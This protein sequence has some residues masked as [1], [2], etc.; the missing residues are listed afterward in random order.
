[1][2]LRQSHD[3]HSQTSIYA[4][5]PPVVRLQPQLQPQLH[6]QHVSFE[7]NQP[8]PQVYGVQ[9]QIQYVQT[10]VLPTGQTIYVNV[11]SPQ[12]YGHQ[13]VHYQQ[14]LQQVPAGMG[15][16]GEQFI[17]VMP[18]AHGGPA[19]TANYSYFA[20]D[21]QAPV[22]PTYVMTSHQQQVEK[23]RPTASPNRG[24]GAIDS[25]RTIQ[26][27]G[28]GSKEKAGRGKRGNVRREPKSPPVAVSP[29]LE[30]FKAKKNRNWTLCDITGESFIFYFHGGDNPCI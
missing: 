29:L 6:Q 3:A 8:Q 23:M 12:Q 17:S 2:G 14:I 13:P 7:Q 11:P 5:T 27:G 25:Q 18:M 4:Q 26:T 19:P 10:H 20:T 21:G 22:G 28:R 30:T 16:N 15:P 9:P 1:M 24:H